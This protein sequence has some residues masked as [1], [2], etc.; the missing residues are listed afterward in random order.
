ML[1]S[2]TTRVTQWSDQ[3]SRIEPM[4]GPST[5]Y[6]HDLISD[7]AKHNDNGRIEVHST[8]RHRSPLFDPRFARLCHLFY[9]WERTRKKQLKVGDKSWQREVVSPGAKG[10]TKGRCAA[11]QA[12]YIRVLQK[13]L[14]IR[15][16]KVTHFGRKQGIKWLV[17]SGIPLVDVPKAAKFAQHVLNKHFNMSYADDTPLSVQLAM[18]GFPEELSGGELPRRV[19]DPAHAEVDKEGVK[20]LLDDMLPWIDKQYEKAKKRNETARYKADR[21]VTEEGVLHYLHVGKLLFLQDAACIQDQFIDLPIFQMKVFSSPHWDPYKKAILA[22][23]AEP[24]SVLPPRKDVPSRILEVVGRL[25]AETASMKEAMH[26]VQSDMAL[27]RRGTGEVGLQVVGLRHL[28][29]QSV[30]GGRTAT[31]GTDGVPAGAGGG[32]AE[33]GSAGEAEAG[34]AAAPGCTTEREHRLEQE[35]WE[36]RAQLAFYQ[37]YYAPGSGGAAEPGEGAEAGGPAV[38]G[39]RARDGAPADSGIAQ[40]LADELRARARVRQAADAVRSEVQGGRYWHRPGHPSG[41]P[42]RGAPE[43]FPQGRTQGGQAGREAVSEGQPGAARGGQEIGRGQPGVV[44]GAGPHDGTAAWGVQP[45]GTRP[46]TCRGEAS[47]DRPSTSGRGSG[48]HGARS[49][50]SAPGNRSHA[51][52]GRG[53]ATDPDDE[54]NEEDPGKFYREGGY[55]WPQVVTVGDAWKDR[56]EFWTRESSVYHATRGGEEVVSRQQLAKRK[57]S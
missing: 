18:A 23:E 39:Q 42:E 50:D 19:S 53:G 34:A 12:R 2:K 40:R 49:G 15:S 35:G 21:D 25:S 28:V 26:G 5:G 48:S 9:L 51:N 43:S 11:T 14:S 32:P 55:P 8:L 41:A 20:E 27:L 13:K 44:A 7:N 1:R 10:P 29:E 22:A 31:A 56:V 30:L 17:K 3:A 33:A 47:A 45:G 36:L 4:V 37:A 52:V 24:D 57:G 54:E 6:T 38:G 16:R 46:S